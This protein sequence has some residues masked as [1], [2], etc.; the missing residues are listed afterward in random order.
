MV[1]CKA[2]SVRE[3]HIRQACGIPEAPIRKALFKAEE[4]LN[5][6]L[7]QV[8]KDEL[9]QFV[10]D[11]L[12]EEFDKEMV[13]DIKVKQKTLSVLGKHIRKVV[14]MEELEQIVERIHNEVGEDVSTADKMRC[15]AE[16]YPNRKKF[17]GKVYQALNK[18]EG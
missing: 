1:K 10:R 11:E 13:N 17:S 6:D 9:I 15:F 12:S 4:N 8:S 16:L 3:D 14:M 2:T 7:T 18:I 5:S